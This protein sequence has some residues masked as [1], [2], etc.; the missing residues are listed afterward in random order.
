MF[1]I[2]LPTPQQGD[3]PVIAGPPSRTCRKPV[4]AIG[5]TREVRRGLGTTDA[6]AALRRSQTTWSGGH[7]PVLRSHGVGWF[8]EPAYGGYLFTTIGRPAYVE[9]SVPSH[10]APE[11][12]ALVDFATPINTYD[13]AEQ[14]CR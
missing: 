12:H 13:P 14:P 7:Q 5:E 11:A 9:V 2:G 3:V 1:L 8:A 10:D 4:A 6:D